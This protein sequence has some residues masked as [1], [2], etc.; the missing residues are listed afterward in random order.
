MAAIP[1]EQEPRIS[2]VIQRVMVAR[3]YD[4]SAAPKSNEDIS[5]I[6]IDVESIAAAPASSE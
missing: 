3:E 6:R 4:P 5:T 2:P 1:A